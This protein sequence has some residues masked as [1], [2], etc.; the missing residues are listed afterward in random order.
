MSAKKLLGKPLPGQPS[1]TIGEI[2]AYL[3]ALRDTEDPNA[4]N[5]L[6]GIGMS[7]LERFGQLNAMAQEL[8]KSENAHK[9]P[10]AL[11]LANGL[12]LALNYMNGSVAEEKHLEHVPTGGFTHFNPLAVKTRPETY[13]INKKEGG[14][15]HLLSKVTLGF[16]AGAPEGDFVAYR[17]NSTG[18]IVVVSSADFKDSFEEKTLKVNS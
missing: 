3:L 9:D 7:I 8:S 12:I 17:D 10:T 4:V 14:R 13:Y 5:T 6:K 16:D 1:L 2:E 15:H 18:E 11:G